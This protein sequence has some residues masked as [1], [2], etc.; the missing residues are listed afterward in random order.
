MFSGY[1]VVI[2]AGRPCLEAR[3]ECSEAFYPAP[4]WR[5]SGG[6]GSG[7]GGN[8][9]GVG[10]SGYGWSSMIPMGS[11]YAHSLSFDY[12]GSNPNN[13]GNR[14]YGFQLRCLQE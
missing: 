11:T 8:L 7:T 6:R 2:F 3:S 12:G 14:A 10:E 4:G 13:Y 5:E 1:F 9:Y